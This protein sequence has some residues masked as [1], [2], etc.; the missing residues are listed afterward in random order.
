M[1][2]IKTFFDKNIKDLN[3]FLIIGSGFFGF[4]AL[5]RLSEKYNNSEF[6]IVDKSQEK[7][8]DLRRNID[9]KKN[10][11]EFIVEDALEFL[12]KSNLSDNLW[13]IPAVPF[14]LAYEFLLK[15]LS[16]RN[17][18]FKLKIN[19]KDILN[20]LPNYL[21]I[22]E[23]NNNIYLSIADFICP[24]DCPEPTQKCYYTG[25]TRVGNLYEIINKSIPEKYYAIIY[26]SFQLA[27]G[28]GGYPLS[29]FYSGFN[30]LMDLRLEKEDEKNIIIGTA[31]RCHG[32]LSFLNLT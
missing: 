19:Y 25:K 3:K 21:K 11:I 20:I 30:F 12:S 10:K 18:N 4:K 29:N 5:K 22:I 17:I 6:I 9:I 28:V 24:D 16:S 32:V 1:K 15:N 23:R 26:R 27:P 8:V 14:H 31:C 13:I 2:K 7:I